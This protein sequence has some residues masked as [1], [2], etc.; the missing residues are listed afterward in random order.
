MLYPMLN[1]V[2]HFRSLEMK[3]PG[4]PLNTNVSDGRASQSRLEREDVPVHLQRALLL[5]AKGQC[6]LDSFFFSPPQ[7]LV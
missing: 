4:V 2:I 3:E 1:V 6:F 7:L 5:P